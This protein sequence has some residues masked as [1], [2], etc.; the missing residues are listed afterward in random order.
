MVTT[1]AAGERDPLVLILAQPTNLEPLLLL[2]RNLPA[3]DQQF[4]SKSNPRALGL[5]VTSSDL[6]NPAMDWM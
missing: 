4:R 2:P 3:L 1:D 5:D 6:G